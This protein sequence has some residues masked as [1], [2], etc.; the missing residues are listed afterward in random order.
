M[1]GEDFALTKEGG[2]AYITINREKALNAYRNSFQTLQKV[3][4]DNR[5]VETWLINLVKA[6]LY[7][8][9]EAVSKTEGVS[10]GRPEN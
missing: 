8:L 9:T 5:P 10:A 6:R 2:V 1:N 4:A 3:R 7:E